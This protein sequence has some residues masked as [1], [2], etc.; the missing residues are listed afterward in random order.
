M[1]KYKVFS[2]PNP[3]SLWDGEAKNHE[4]AINDYLNFSGKFKECIPII[5]DPKKP[6]KEGGLKFYVLEDKK[7]NKE[8]YEIFLD[9]RE[10]S[11]T[12]VYKNAICYEL[13]FKN[14][15]L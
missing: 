10:D 9:A 4:Q 5:C 14:S 7:S 11:S 6:K 1:P 2:E 8:E 15:I 13:K 3:N 12:E